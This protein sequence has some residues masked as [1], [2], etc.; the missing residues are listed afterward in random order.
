MWFVWKAPLH[1]VTPLENSIRL[2]GF[3]PQT[4]FKQPID[5]IQRIQQCSM[6]IGQDALFLKRRFHFGNTGDR[7]GRRINR[8][9][10]QGS[11]TQQEDE[12]R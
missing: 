12:T 6:D 8:R 11:S 2:D 3:P 1:F 4:Q 10:H 5:L 7:Y 9:E